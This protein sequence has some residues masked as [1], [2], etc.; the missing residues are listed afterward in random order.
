MTPHTDAA[1]LDSLDRIDADNE[2]QHAY[3]MSRLA[4]DDHETAEI[5]ARGRLALK[6]GKSPQCGRTYRGQWVSFTPPG[7]ADRKRLSDMLE[8]RR[9]PM[10]RTDSTFLAGHCN[11][12]QFEQEPWVGDYYRSIA[13]AA[14]V[15]TTGK[16][17]KG[18]LASFPGD[19]MAWVGGRGD[20]ERVAREK[21]LKVEGDVTCDYSQ[22]ID[23]LPPDIDVA[24]DIVEQKVLQMMQ[25]N[26][27]IEQERKAEDVFAEAKDAIKP[28]WAA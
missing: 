7:E 21:G 15:D 20:V 5:R 22:Q 26:P 14:G 6:R 28:P 8:Q 19:P 4:G 23:E 9:G 13:D 27:N 2:V 18:G 1:F 12:S 24:P 11:G 17:Y 16:V 3:E 10:V 25:D